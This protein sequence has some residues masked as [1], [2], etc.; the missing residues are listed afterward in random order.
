MADEPD[1]AK[2]AKLYDHA[3]EPMNDV[4]TVEALGMNGEA[5]GMNGEA[6]LPILKDFKTGV[7][8]GEKSVWWSRFSLESLILNLES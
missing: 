2:C 4:A 7:V 5:L 6:W 1:A 3:I 8:C